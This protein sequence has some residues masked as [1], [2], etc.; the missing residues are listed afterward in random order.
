[1]SLE[2]SSLRSPAVLWAKNGFDSFG[3]PKLDTAI[4]VCC[5]IEY[6]RS[7]GRDAQASNEQIAAVMF[8][9]QDIPVESIVW[10]GELA[11]LPDDLTTLT[12][13]M[14]VIDFARV[15][16]IQN[17]NSLRKAMLA[18]FNNKLPTV[19]A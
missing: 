8:V 1:M 11:D 4:E 6:G 16:D 9:C 5:R 3:R 2:T 14:Q 15:P 18:R 10:D 12:D 19:S 7:V 17:R 13:L